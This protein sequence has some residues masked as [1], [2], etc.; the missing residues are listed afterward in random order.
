MIRSLYYLKA[1]GFNFVDT[2]INHFEQVQNF[3]ELKQLVSSCT[4]CQF[5][6]TRKFSLMEPKIKNAKLLILDVFGQK[7]E[8]ESGILLNS[9]KGEKLKHYIY[10]IL[11]LCD[12]DFYFSYLFKCFCNGKF[13]DF[14]LQSCLPFFWNEL[15]LIQPAF[16]LCLGEY[17]FKSLGFKDY[18]ILKGEVFSY[19]N[20]FIMPSYDLD[21][22]EKNPSYEKNFIQDLKKIK[23]FL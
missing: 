12:E 8:N 18:H 5:S 9:K 3:Q 16:L 19:K 2:H 17:T 6:K 4:L 22:I 1:M 13:D 7:S 20:F 15:K 11:G 10:Q 21:F 14:S 23:G